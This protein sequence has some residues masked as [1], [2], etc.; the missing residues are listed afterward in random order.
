MEF[1]TARELAALPLRRAFRRNPVL[2]RVKPILKR[3]LRKT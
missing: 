2:M 3:L 1:R